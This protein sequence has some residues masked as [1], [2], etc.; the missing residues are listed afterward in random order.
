MLTPGIHVHVLGNGNEKVLYSSHKEANV[1][2]GERN[3]THSANVTFELIYFT[4]QK[5]INA[6]TCPKGKASKGRLFFQRQRVQNN[7]IFSKPVNY[8]D[9]KYTDLYSTVKQLLYNPIMEVIKDFQGT[10]KDIQPTSTVEL[11]VLR[12][13][14][15][16]EHI[17]KTIAM[18]QQKTTAEVQLNTW[19]F[20]QYITKEFRLDSSRTRIRV[21]PPRIHHFCLWFFST[22]HHVLHTHT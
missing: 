20:N 7:K 19:F 6:L 5:C 10:L 3:W 14:L 11:E 2:H 22:R 16:V 4:E 8:G 12:H 13:K 17:E 18:F 21:F 15:T 1:K 9:G